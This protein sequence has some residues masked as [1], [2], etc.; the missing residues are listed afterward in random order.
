M[1]PRVVYLHAGHGKTG[2]SF[3][4]SCL[5]MSSD[6]LAAQKI[7]Y[8]DLT[9]SFANARAGRIT[10]GNIHTGKMALLEAV[11][12]TCRHLSEDQAVLFS[13]EELFAYLNGGN[14]KAF[15]EKVRD[16]EFDLR[17]LCFIR[18]PLEHAVSL[19]QQ[20]V[21]RS[22]NTDRFSQ[23]LGNYK[24]PREVKNFVTTLNEAGAKVSIRNYSRHSKRLAGVTEDWL[25]L[26]QDSLNQPERL[27]VNRSV[28]NGEL[29]LQIEFSK[30]LGRRAS[31]LISDPL[32]N[33][34]PDVRSEYPAISREELEPFLARMRSSISKVN[35]VI[36]A[37]EVYSVP[38][39]D[40]AIKRFPDPDDSMLYSFSREQLEVIAR[41]LSRELTKLNW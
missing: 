4:Q 23:F 8:P 20:T 1:T 14:A 31:V 3:L 35:P 41:K 27:V 7:H 33:N 11:E 24:V 25:G 12:E 28:T 18:D 10:A 39:T 21:K 29:A 17:V 13:H 16:G 19:Y 30:F 34:L 22:G 40:D 37:D 9:N 36:P 38:S 6:V 15:L 32:C 5:A 26:Q 2:S